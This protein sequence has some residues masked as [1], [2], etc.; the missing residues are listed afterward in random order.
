MAASAEVR[1]SCAP[2]GRS[3]R[4]EA[5][6]QPATVQPARCRARA[7]RAAATRSAGENIPVLQL[8]RAARQVLGLRRADRRALPAGRAGHR[9]AVCVRASGASGRRPARWPGAAS[10]LALVALAFIDLDTSCCPTTSRCRCCG[11]ACLRSLRLD[12]SRCST[13]VVGR[14]RGLPVAVDR[15]W[16]SSC[17]PARRAWATATSSCWPRSAPGS[18]GRCFPHHPAGL[19]RRGGRRDRR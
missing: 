17:S 11:P 13:R 2:A 8:A 6:R 12:R 18:A 14:G 10:L 19:G 3:G 5:P 9:R 1:R 15:L 4:A 16:L 7:A